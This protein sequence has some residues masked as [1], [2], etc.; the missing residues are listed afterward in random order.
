MKITVIGAGY[1][2][3]VTGACL[4][5]LGHQIL[6]VDNN[7]EKIA[8]LNAAGV[9]IYEPGLQELLSRNRAEGR[10]HFTTE[11]ADAVDHGEVIFIAVGTPSQ[12]DGSADLQHVLAVA[13]QV[14]RHL[15]NFKVVVNK[16]TVPVGTAYR[17]HDAIATELRKRGITE[18]LFEVISNPEFLKE[19][20]AIDDFMRPDR[21][22]IGLDK[23]P[24]YEVVQQKMDQLYA[25]FNRHHARTLWMDVRS[26]ELTKY[27]ANAM[28][29]TRI[30]FM[31]E[32]ANLADLMGADVDCV[33]RGIGADARIGHGFLYAGTGYGGSCFPKDTRALVQTALDCGSTMKVVSAVEHVNDS[34][35]TVLLHRT[36]QYFGNDLRGLKFA[37]WGLAFK[38]NTD[39]MRE[40]PSRVVIKNLLL[41]G[42]QVHAFD[43]IAAKEALEAITQDMDEHPQA[44]QR[45]KMHATA[46]EATEQADALLVLTEWK[47]FHHPDFDLLKSQMKRPL[48]LDGRNLYD[49]QW[50]QDMGIAYQGIGRRNDLALTLKRPVEAPSSEPLMALS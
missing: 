29:A 10:I 8:L 22:V 12:E 5:E 21:I 37:V 40:A 20:A 15:K 44:L 31:N 1:V 4:A 7:P 41:R 48:I 39:D 11:M 50:L 3:L 46:Y 16:S 9:P 45:L 42:A 38:P 26:A 36:L 49:P 14:G 23:G 34:Q 35:K 28:L 6:C 30:S 27:A 19:G 17:V 24:H 33:R 13:G 32:I 2:G 18:H 47:T 25:S 43:P